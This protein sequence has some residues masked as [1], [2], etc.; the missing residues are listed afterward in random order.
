VQFP[1]SATIIAQS[2]GQPIKLSYLVTVGGTT[3]ASEV[4]VLTVQAATTNPGSP[5]VFA[6]VA[7][8]LH[9][10]A[11]TITKDGLLAYVGNSL[12]HTVSVIDINSRKVVDTIFGTPSAFQMLLNADNSRLY[13]SSFKAGTIAVI[14]TA[15]RRLIM[16]MTPSG[17]ERSAWMALNADESR[18]F[19]ACSF[20]GF[21]AVHDTKTG[22][23]LNRITTPPMPEG[24]AL[25]PDKTQVFI[26]TSKETMIT[27]ANG[28]GGGL[29]KV[30][31]YTR[32]TQS[33][34]IAFNPNNKPY[35]RVYVT[36]NDSL[37]IIDTQTNAV[38]KSLSGFTYSWGA[39]MKPKGSECYVGAVG[40]G[41][42]PGNRDSLY[43]INTETEQVIRRYAGFDNIAGIA[44]TP[45]GEIALI[46]NHGTGKVSF[47]KT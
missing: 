38:T 44:F 23:L 40:P 4:Q 43:I 24:V 33:E 14:D 1:I 3:V 9:A 39:T 27:N 36:G 10:H 35:P 16:T 21:V 26:S 20:G 32:F 17:G 19:V 7:V 41:G 22:A 34:G 6:T 45:D 47:Y 25:N 8:G 29:A 18:L 11:I 2:A 30:S 46:V 37:A 42:T 13:V 31:G 28:L 15:T 5:G 12:D